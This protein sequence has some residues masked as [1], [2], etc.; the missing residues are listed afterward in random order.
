MSHPAWPHPLVPQ[1]TPVKAVFQQRDFVF[2]NCYL[3]PESANYKSCCHVATCCMERSLSALSVM[4]T[5]PLYLSVYLLSQWR[6]SLTGGEIPVSI[7]DWLLRA[8]STL[9]R[10]LD[11]KYHKICLIFFKRYFSRMMHIL[12]WRSL[13]TVFMARQAPFSKTSEGT[14]FVSVFVWRTNPSFSAVRSLVTFPSVT[15]HEEYV[16]IPQRWN[17]W[18]CHDIFY[19]SCHKSIFRKK[20]DS[21][22]FLVYHCFLFLKNHSR[23]PDRQK[24]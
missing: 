24:N 19:F 9:S 18:G 17:S 1:W 20:A 4:Y 12:G 7:T 10:I 2:A 21:L 16:Q 3:P 6:S 23:L 11:F 22:C 8:V 15:W 5:G 14:T 13:V